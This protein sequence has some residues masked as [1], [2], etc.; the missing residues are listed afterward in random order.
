V[1]VFFGVVPMINFLADFFEEN[2]A[3]FLELL[4]AVEEPENSQLDPDPFRK[5][6]GEPSDFV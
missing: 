5:Q 6:T 4:C 2:I 1:E 3:I